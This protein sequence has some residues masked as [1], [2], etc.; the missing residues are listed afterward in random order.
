MKKLSK[1]ISS[2][3]V[4]TDI[5]NFTGLFNHFQYEEDASFVDF[6]KTYIAIHMAVAQEISPDF[7]VSSTGDGILVIFM[8]EKHHMNGYAFGLLM[9]KKLTELCDAFNETH[10]VHVDFGIGLDSGD[11]WKIERSYEDKVVHTYLGSV[12]NRASRIESQTK[13]YS[14]INMLIG[15][16]IFK[17][18]IN[19]LFPKFYN[20][21]VNFHENYELSIS[22][23]STFIQTSKKLMLFYISDINI[24]G[25]KDP[26]PL[27]KVAPYFVADSDIF[28]KVISNLVGANE[29]KTLKEIIV[30]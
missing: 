13:N 28:W 10:Q 3:A 18:L 5:R 7:Y 8:S 30:K 20:E 14:G 15:Q 12:I 27:F 24:R 23:D 4:V 16:H 6:M 9:H 26:V 25:I 11:V 17:R 21:I 29:M 22:D 1:N 2:T 19:D